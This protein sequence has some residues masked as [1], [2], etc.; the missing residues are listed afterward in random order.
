MTA[1]EKAQAYALKKTGLKW[2]K[3]S[4]WDDDDRRAYLAANAEFRQRNPGLFTPAEQAAGANYA[5]A[6]ASTDPKF[7]YLSE[8]WKEGSAQVGDLFRS[9][10]SVGEGVKSAFNL[11][12]WLIPAALIAFVGILVWRTSSAVAPSAK[13]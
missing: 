5:T 9:V 1:I 6:A 11:T 2:A 7:S 3:L 12:R 8:S 10:A 4:S 13:K